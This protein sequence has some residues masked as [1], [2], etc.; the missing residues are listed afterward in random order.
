MFLGVADPPPS[1][2]VLSSALF[3]HDPRLLLHSLFQRSFLPISLSPSLRPPPPPPPSMLNRAYHECLD[4]CFVQQYSM[5]HRLETNKLRNVAKFFAHLLATDA[6][7]WGLLS[8][9]RLTEEDTSSS[10]RI[11]IKILLQVGP[12][13]AAP[14][15]W[16]QSSRSMQ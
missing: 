15:P 2:S 5:I 4:Q 6:M 13:V 1:P 7:P 10:S 8:Y 14:H 3:S 16:H 12:C 9:I 11:F